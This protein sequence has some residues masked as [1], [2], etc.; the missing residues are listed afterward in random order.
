MYI[1]C[2]LIGGTNIFFLQL[3][4]QLELLLNVE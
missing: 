3:A 1:F 2:E 4:T